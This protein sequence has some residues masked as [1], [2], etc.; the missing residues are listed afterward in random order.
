MSLFRNK[1]R[2]ESLRLQHWNYAS[3][4]LYFITLCTKDRKHFFGKIGYDE[5]GAACAHLSAI[6]EIV[7]SEWLKTFEMRPDMNL[8]MGE[9]IIMPDHFHA[10][11]GIGDNEFNKTVGPRP[12]DPSVPDR[13]NQFGPQ[14]KNLASVVRGFKIGVTRDARMIQPEFAWQPLFYE[15]IIRHEGAFD[16]ISNYIRNN[17]AKWQEKISGKNPRK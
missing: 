4:G 11:I 8:W 1:Y 5:N 14:S 3:A 17:P 10:V 13:Q 2:N 9:F 15:H 7:K 16:R 6:G 12:T